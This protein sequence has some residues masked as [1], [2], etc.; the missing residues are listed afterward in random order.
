MEEVL[1]IRLT[2]QH[3]AMS[4]HVCPFGQEEM[5]ERVGCCL[6]YA[7][8]LAIR[9]HCVEDS[10]QLQRLVSCCTVLLDMPV[11]PTAVCSGASEKSRKAKHQT[12][13][14]FLPPW[15][16]REVS[17]CMQGSHHVTCTT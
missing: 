1:S 2:G 5:D 14:L 4:G 13:V 11:S 15:Q 17:A 12:Y 16:L 6:A 8:E 10:G 3:C 9:Q 7:E